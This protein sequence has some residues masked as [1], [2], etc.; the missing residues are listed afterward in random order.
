MGTRSTNDIFS[1]FSFRLKNKKNPYKKSWGW[2]NWNKFIFGYL[3]YSAFKKSS[4]QAS[5][6]ITSWRIYIKCLETYACRVKKNKLKDRAAFLICQQRLWRHVSDQGAI[7]S[8]EWN[9]THWNSSE[10]HNFVTV[11]MKIEFKFFFQTNLH[12][13]EYQKD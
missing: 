2:N 10:N 13:L 11:V 12:T 4:H 6:I 9:E 8:T 3:R 1:Y 7:V 5:T